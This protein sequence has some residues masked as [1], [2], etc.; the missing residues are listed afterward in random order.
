MAQFASRLRQQGLSPSSLPLAINSGPQGNC[1]LC[2]TCD[3]FPC[4]IAAKNDAE[5]CALEPAIATGRVDLLTKTYARRLLL[6]PDGHS[7][8]AVE[9]IEAGEVKIYAAKIVVVACNAVNSA[10]LLLRSADTQAPNGVANKSGVVGRHYMVHNQSA[11]MGLSLRYNKTIFQKTL[12]INDFY[13]GDKSLPYPMG[14]VQML[15]ENCKVACFQPISRTC[16]GLLIEMAR[17]SIDWLRLSEDLP[18]PE[19][20]VTVNGE[21]IK[22]AVT[23]NNMKGHDRLVGKMKSA[24]QKGGYPIVLTKSLAAHATAHQCGTVRFGDTPSKAALDPF[25]RSFDHAN[26]FV[27]DASFFSV[28]CG[29]KSGPDHCST[30][31]EGRAQ[32]TCSKTT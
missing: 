4:K 3:G 15:R 11:L 19:N 28:V 12:A 8:S 6:S 7:I 2:K 14:Q 31:T 9:V 13:F 23:R 25:C 26:L 5:T 10:A 16:L 21:T 20:R 29:G 32:T 27:V 1:V 18:D 24:L 22:L 30:G 17:H